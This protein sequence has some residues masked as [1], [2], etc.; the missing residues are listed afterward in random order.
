MRSHMRTRPSGAEV[1]PLLKVVRPQSNDPQPSLRN[2][3][4]SLSDYSPS[5][6]KERCSQALFLLKLTLASLIMRSKVA[7]SLETKRSPV[8][9]SL[10][11]NC[12]RRFKDKHGDEY[13]C[14]W[15]QSGLALSMRSVIVMGTYVFATSLISSLGATTL[16]ASEIMRQVQPGPMH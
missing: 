5:C 4:K 10:L 9:S 8:H 11:Q 3:S 14:Q 6:P 16:A 2:A 1:K 12:D 15:L 13:S 7:D